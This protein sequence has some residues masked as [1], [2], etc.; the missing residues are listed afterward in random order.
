MPLRPE[1][2]VPPPNP[3]PELAGTALH[4]YGLLGRGMGPMALAARARGADVDGCDQ[5]GHVGAPGLERAGL[6]VASGHDPA[7]LV[8]RHLVV[9]TDARPD[10]PEVAAARARGVLHH[11]S[12][13]LDAILARSPSVAVT[14]T[15]GK[16]TV[17][18]L[19]GMALAELGR[20]PMLVVGVDVPALDGPFRDG[21]GPVVAE[22]DD[23]DGSIARV[24][25]DISVVTNSWSDHPLFGRTRE[26]VIAD[27]ARHVELVPADG[28]VVLGR[29]RNLLPVVRDARA[30]VWRLGRDIDV[31]DVAVDRRGR[32]VRLRDVDGREHDA[33]V[34]LLGGNVTDNAGLAFAVLRALDV[35]AVDAAGALGALD[36]LARRV[37]PLTDGT[38]VLVLDDLGKHPEAVAATIAAAR[39]VTPG[40]LHVAY[41][42][43][44][45][46]DVLR[47][48]TRWA[49]VLGAADTVVVLPVERRQQFPVPRRA[50]DDWPI[51]AGLRAD[52]V[53][54]RATAADR[55]VERA[56]PGDTI[57]VMG[58]VDDLSDLS[59]AV[60]DRV[61]VRPTS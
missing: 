41:E 14:G 51:R 44:S 12:D 43:F 5:Y 39:A 28:R 21:R 6:P 3:L 23:A 53:P 33:R 26:E 27:V 48:R 7:H 47:W 9:P 2:H 31:V 32:V 42:P 58:A 36:R 24:H 13:L 60:A 10:E 29:G 45:H 17:A 40:R 11:R 8:G 16:G 20:D 46:T 50:P 56:E 49:A 1:M 22:A 19:V 57:L 18:A 34:S 54:D 15:H 38:T 61:G 52:L 35:P 59:R 4:V 25:A 37:E 30:P 55:L